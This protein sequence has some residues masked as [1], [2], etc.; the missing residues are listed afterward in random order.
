MTEKTTTYAPGTFCWPELTSTDQGAAEKFYTALFGWTIKETP[1]GPD[2]HYTIFLKDGQDVSALAQMDKEQEKR[3][4]PSNWLSYVST[5]NVD[6]S[7]EKAKSLG[8]TLL[9]GPF[10]V[11]EHGRMAV[12]QD[13]TGAA[14]ALWQ[15]K[16]H[17]GAARIDQPFALV[18]TELMTP[19]PK[20]STPF[21]TGLFGWTTETMAMGGYDY[22][23]W[24]R[25]KDSAGGM[26][27]ITPEMGKMPAHWIP[28]FG[29][30]DVDAIVKKAKD[31]GGK[32]MLEPKDIPGVGRMAIVTDP[33]GAHFSIL[34]PD[35]NMTK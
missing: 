20:K 8:A 35:P 11:M 7:V 33:T 22:T 19:D 24:K 14:V 23:I 1:M 5:T 13:P 28:Y 29:V 18:W 4:I 21:Y 26:M 30:T 2:S 27:Q 10:D 15:A 31:L 3:G 6:A 25:G 12:L 16:A 17:P 34:Q 32:I 9:A